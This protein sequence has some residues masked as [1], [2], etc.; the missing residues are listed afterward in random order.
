C[1]SSIFSIEA[2]VK[3]IVNGLL[4]FLFGSASYRTGCYLRAMVC[5][6]ECGRLRMA[7]LISNRLQKKQGVFVSY[8][9]E[10]DKTIDLRHPVGVVIGDGVKVG[11]GVVI[12][13]NVTLGGAR[14]GDAKSMNYPEVGDNTV[15]FAG[16][17][18][19]GKVKVGSNCIVGANSVVLCDMPDNSVAV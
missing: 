17:V 8:K 5:L 14:I 3:L 10:I 12:Y 15:I 4:R 18:V 19:L 2:V 1:L 11:K 6:K 9:A 16:A 13:Q 7:R